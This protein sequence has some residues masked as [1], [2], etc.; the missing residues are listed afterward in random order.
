METGT[1]P[2]MSP[3]LLARRRRNAARVAWGLFAAVA[4]LYGLGFLIPR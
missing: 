3:E 4:L 1:F 2:V